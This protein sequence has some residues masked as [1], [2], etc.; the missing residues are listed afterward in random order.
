MNNRYEAAPLREGELL[1]FLHIPKTAGITFYNIVRFYF[2][3]ERTSSQQLE[4]FMRT[5]MEQRLSYQLISGHFGY[6]VEGLFGRMPAYITMLRDP[7]E[8]VISNYYYAYHEIN[9][10]LHRLAVTQNLLEFIG[11]PRVLSLWANIQT[12]YLSEVFDYDRLFRMYDQP[13]KHDLN[14]RGDE[15][16]IIAAKCDPARLITARERLQTFRFVGITEQFDHSLQLLFYTFNWS[17]ITSYPTYNVTPNRPRREAVSPEIYQIINQ[18]YAL[19][20]ALYQYATQLF[21]SRYDGMVNALLDFK[22]SFTP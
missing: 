19:D 1:Y 7:V 6:H 13:K 15:A 21:A 14:L 10:Y 17:A 11:D 20:I 16:A 3:P 5:T 12:S 9:H 8:Q 18:Y 22:R 4:Q 2:P